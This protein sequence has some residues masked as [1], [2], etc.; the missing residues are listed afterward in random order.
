M[1]RIKLKEKT[2][3]QLE[4]L[5]DLEDRSV[6]SLANEIL[7]AWLD[8]NYEAVMEEELDEDQEDE[9]EEDDEN[10]EELEDED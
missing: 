5:A 8:D 1:Y 4:Q 7:R 3:E 9:E 6:S 10:E 2:Y